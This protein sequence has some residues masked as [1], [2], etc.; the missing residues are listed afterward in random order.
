MSVIIPAFNEANR[1][2]KTLVSV[3]E[4][5]ES[6]EQ[7]YEVIVVDDG[8]D[9]GTDKIVEEFTKHS[10]A[11]KLLKNPENR[12]KGYSVRY[13][14]LNSSGRFLLF[15][16]ADG[17]TSIDQITKM[18][19]AV[20]QG[21]DVAIGSRAIYSRTTEV[22]TVW[23]RRFIGRVFNALVNIII[24]PGIADTQC[25]FKMFTR[26]AASEIFSRQR[27]ERFSFDV[28]LLFLARKFEYKIVEVPV[29]WVNVPGS[30][31]NLATDS[32]A[33]LLDIIKFRARDLSG[34]YR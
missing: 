18:L 13:G 21:A 7:S 16:D 4:F 30:K 1:L 22:K 3:R 27:A 11:I 25:G 26:R 23:Y 6:I 34:G 29:N 32:M 20:E 12:G 2:P 17:S 33:M 24:L 15:N 8:S 28:E 5:F 19:S 9:D 31:V 14:M 10:P